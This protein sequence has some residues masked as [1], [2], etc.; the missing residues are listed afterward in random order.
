MK[1]R[2]RKHMRAQLVKAREKARR[3]KAA[4]GFRETYE[5]MLF[6]KGRTLS[7]ELGVSATQAAWPPDSDIADFFDPAKRK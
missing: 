3:F 1:S 6:D 2:R 4:A 5:Q 7:A